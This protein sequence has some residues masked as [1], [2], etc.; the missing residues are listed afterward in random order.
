MQAVR[1]T[2]TVHKSARELVHDNNLAVFDDIVFVQVE[3]LM[4]FQRLLNV[5]VQIGVLDFRN[6]VDV[7]ELFCFSCTAVRQLNRLF[8]AVDDIV[9]V[10]ALRQRASAF[11]CSS[12][13]GSFTLRHFRFVVRLFFQRHRRVVNVVFIV[14][15]VHDLLFLLF[16]RLHR[17]KQ[18]FL[19][20]QL[21]VEA[22]RKGA[23]ELVNLYVQLR[24]LFTLA[25]NDKGSSCF[26]D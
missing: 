10:T 12:F 15:V 2:S 9:P 26:V 17:R 14:F 20:L 18:L 24:R 13:C 5:V 11:G 7:E 1:I 3:Q 19:F 4:R 25:R 22:T 6:V 16:G 23:D 8:L 21:I